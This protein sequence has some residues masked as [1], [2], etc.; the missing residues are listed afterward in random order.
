[1]TFPYVRVESLINSTTRS[2]MLVLLK[3]LRYSIISAVCKPT[4]T[5]AYNEYDVS[6]YSCINSGRQTG[7]EIVIKKSC[8]CL[9]T[10]END[11]RKMCPSG[12]FLIN[13][14]FKEN[15]FWI[16]NSLNLQSIMA[17]FDGQLLAL[18]LY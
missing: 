16:K 11:S 1:M 12:A 5:A 6:L 10:G 15:N 13:Y 14:F 9:Y 4:E 2:G 18:I 8:A 7:S 3:R 17:D